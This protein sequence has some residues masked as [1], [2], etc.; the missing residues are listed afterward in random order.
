MDQILA[1]LNSIWDLVLHFK[2]MAPKEQI[3]GIVLILIAIWKSSLL[4]PYWDK[5]G[6]WKVL[7]PAILGIV[8]GFVY[9]PVVSAETIWESLRSGLLAI[10]VHK[11]FVGIQTIPGIGEKY[12]KVVNYIEKLLRKPSE[13]AE[14]KG[15]KDPTE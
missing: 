8:L 4:K 7:V 11:L 14:K 12:L 13:D 15:V 9:L 10:A 3:T 2:T 1:V 5:F 6:A